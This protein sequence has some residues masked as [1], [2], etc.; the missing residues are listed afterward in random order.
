MLNNIYEYR[1]NKKGR[2]C[3]RT[4]SRKELLQKLTELGR[5]DIYTTQMRLCRVDKYGVTLKDGNG[6]PLWTTWS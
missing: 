1:I 3:F 4:T 6:R 5:P 2:E